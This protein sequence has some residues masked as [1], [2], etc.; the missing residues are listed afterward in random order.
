MFALL[1]GYVVFALFFG[2]P[3]KT[4]QV[5]QPT[6]VVKQVVYRSIETTPIIVNINF[7]T[8]LLL[9][10]FEFYLSCLSHHQPF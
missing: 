3:A 8:L 10:L 9:F 7:F 4:K 2:K 1:V 5:V 6:R